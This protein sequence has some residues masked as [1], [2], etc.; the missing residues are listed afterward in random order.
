MGD[1]AYPSCLSTKS[2]WAALLEAK[3]SEEPHIHQIEPTNRCAYSC[4]MCPRAEKMTRPL[5]LMDVDLYRKLIDEIAGFAPA[6]RR[7]EIELFHF[8]ESLIH[9]RLPEMVRIGSER[10][11]KM[12]LSV[13]PPHLTPD[14]AADLIAAEPFKIIISLDGDDAETYRRIR[15]KAARFDKAV[16]NLM[17]FAE[18]YRRSNRRTDVVLRVIK[19][20]QNEHQIA[21]MRQRWEA[22]GLRFEER[23]FFP[24]TEDD[25]ADLG[26]FQRYPPAMPCPFPWQYMVVQWDG[27]VVPCCR[28]YNAVNVMG[29]VRDQTLKEIWNGETYRGFRRQHETGEFGGND[30]CRKCTAIYCR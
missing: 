23:T 1:T 5:G 13:N 20:Y 27:A 6:V 22:E 9:P 28:D 19:M 11:L 4:V 15:G 26:D 29:N 10:G 30:F 7:K 12:T 21:A 2:G 3:R 24:W 25:L 17:Q 8:G 18:L 14:I 16:D